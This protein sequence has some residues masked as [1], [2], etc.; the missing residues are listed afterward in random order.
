LAI[1]TVP[2]LSIRLNGEQRIARANGVIAGGR[3]GY[4]LRVT[5][6]GTMAFRS[7][8]G[9]FQSWA[10]TRWLSAQDLAALRSL[11]GVT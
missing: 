7:F 9:L 8:G 3:G 11:F 10:A 4:Y 5:G 2:D 1:D 6:P